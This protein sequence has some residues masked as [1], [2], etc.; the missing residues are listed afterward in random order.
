MDLYNKRNLPITNSPSF[1]PGFLLT[2]PL[3][4]ARTQTIL[5]GCPHDPDQ[6]KGMSL[7][8]QIRKAWGMRSCVQMFLPNNSKGV[9]WKYFTNLNF[10]FSGPKSMW[11]PIWFILIK[12]KICPAF[13]QWDLHHTTSIELFRKTPQKR[14]WKRMYC[15]IL[16]NSWKS[17][18]VLKHFSNWCR[19]EADRLSPICANEL[20]A[21]RKSL[22]ILPVSF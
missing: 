6:K 18:P 9:W 5:P 10:L 12:V 21:I 13:L 20:S 16:W 2:F 17:L 8:V 14:N 3:K 15:D 7:W 1:L 19:Q 4:T 22:Q 11:C